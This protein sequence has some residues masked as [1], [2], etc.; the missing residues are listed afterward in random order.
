MKFDELIKKVY[1]DPGG[2][3]SIQDTF[4]E[5]K[6]LNSSV[7]LD[8]IKDWFERTIERKKNLRGFNSYISKGPLDEFEVDLF[9]VN[10]LGQKEY[11]HGLLSI[12][13][14]TKVMWVIPIPSKSGVD[15]LAGM[16]QIINNMGKPKKIY[17]D[18]EPGMVKSKDFK[19]G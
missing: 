5:V 11:P 3:G 1:H 10:Y 14:F 8:D 4:K 7:K 16:K 9:D 15:I 13:N 17:S 18:E 6:K 19:T 12:D 2:Y